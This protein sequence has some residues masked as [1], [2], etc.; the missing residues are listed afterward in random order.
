MII[1]IVS[2]IH[3]VGDDSETRM[4]TALIRCQVITVDYHGFQ[5]DNGLIQPHWAVNLAEIQWI[6]P[7][8]VLSQN[9]SGQVSIVI[10]NINRTFP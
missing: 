9:I 4:T 1:R 6:S 3:S 7:A 2:P 5:S 8:A 10:K